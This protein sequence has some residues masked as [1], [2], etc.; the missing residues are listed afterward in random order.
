MNVFLHNVAPKSE[1]D[2]SVS[3]TAAPA[4]GVATAAALKAAASFYQ[5]IYILVLFN[6]HRC[7]LIICQI[8]RQYKAQ[9]GNSCR[10]NCCSSCTAAAIAAAV[11]NAAEVIL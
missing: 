11:D 5:H 3:T 9:Q 1:C 4:I 6:V 10:Y 7:I 8:T 2:H